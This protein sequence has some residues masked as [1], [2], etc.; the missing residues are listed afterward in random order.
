MDKAL[1][2]LV[3]ISR[4]VGRDKTLVLGEF[5]NTSVKT[6]D[7]RYMYIKASGTALKDMS[8]KK[9]W[10]RLKLDSVR[11][12]LTD[13]KFAKID[14]DKKQDRLAK[15]LLSACEDNVGGGVRPSV[16]S[17]FHSIL[18]KYVIHLH[19]AAALA[20][21]CAENGRAEL[22]K[23]FRRGK[24]KAVWVPCASPGCELVEK[25]K[26]SISRYDRLPQVLF[27]QNHGLVVTADNMNTALKL[28]RKTISIC[29]AGL[30]QLRTVKIEKA[31]RR[32]IAEAV[33]GIR[34][35]LSE[36]TGRD[37]AVR[38]FIDETIAGFMAGK[39]AAKIYSQR[40]VPSGMAHAIT[41]DELVYA[42]GPAVWLDKWDKQALINKLKR[43]VK[44]PSGFLIKPLGLFVAGDKEKASFIKDVICAHLFIRRQAAGFGGIHFLNKQQREFIYRIEG[45][46]Q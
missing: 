17:G 29:K 26:E 27:L 30:K 6:E 34:D 14:T 11:A 28:V 46:K 38:F 45:Q 4:A 8:V 31:D 10:R 40:A 24:I 13:K 7:G 20:Y 25:I 16:E 21:L 36:I 22:E 18:D 15:L 12:I 33:S 1:A 2:E 44:L 5:G 35:V 37:A 39:E 9:G 23:L 3:K 19:P 41:L 43:R 32:R 42:G